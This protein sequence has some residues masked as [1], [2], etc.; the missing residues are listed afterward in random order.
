MQK[1]AY[2]ITKPQLH[3]FYITLTQWGQSYQYDL[4]VIHTSI[5]HKNILLD[6]GVHPLFKE[7]GNR[8]VIS[9]TGT[10]HTVGAVNIQ[11]IK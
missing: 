10:F 11:K 8:A 9:Q 3:I 1:D 4:E 5:K 2:G 7:L 6:V